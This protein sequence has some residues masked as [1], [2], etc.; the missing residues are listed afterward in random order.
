MFLL[1]K[2]D[3]KYTFSLFYLVSLCLS[4]SWHS[5]FLLRGGQRQFNRRAAFAA[6]PDPNVAAVEMGDLPNQ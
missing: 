3:N 6:L 2:P 1:P 4:S 5:P